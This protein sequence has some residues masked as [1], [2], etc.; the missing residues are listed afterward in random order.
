MLARCCLLSGHR[1][2]FCFVLLDLQMPVLDGWST[3]RLLRAEHGTA[4]PIVACTASD[5]SSVCQPGGI[6]VQQHAL[7]CGVDV[8][9]TKPMVVSQLSAALQQL[10]VGIP[11]LQAAGTPT[12]ANATQA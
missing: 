2:D 11:Q 10:Q 3:A 1:G 7:A 9:L 8:C 6:S 4:L 5:L 12:G